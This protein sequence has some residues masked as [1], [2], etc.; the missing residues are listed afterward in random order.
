MVKKRSRLPLI[1]AVVVIVVIL[2]ALVIFSGMQ[3]GQGLTP[4]V[5]VGDEFIFDIIGSSSASPNATVPETFY[6]INMTELYKVTV[7]D[8]N[9]TKVSIDTKWRF[10][11]GTEF[12][13]AGYVK[14]DSGTVFPSNGFW[15]IYASNLKVDDMVRPV[16]GQ[17]TVN[18]TDTKEYASGVTREINTVSWTEELYDRDDPTGGTT[19]NKF[20]IIQFDRETGMLVQLTDIQIY[21]NPQLTLTTT[22]KLKESNV[23]AVS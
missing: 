13:I 17:L 7:T 5:K 10:E 1:A 16:M 9:G 11:N 3:S 18:D 21:N 22:W 14:I 8:V 4:G 6:Q 2:V 12:D 15:P 19:L 23:W 20:T